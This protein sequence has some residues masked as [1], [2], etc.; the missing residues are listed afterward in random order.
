MSFSPPFPFHAKHVFPREKRTLPAPGVRRKRCEPG[1]EVPD[2][3]AIDRMVS[4]SSP[5]KNTKK[6]GSLQSLYSLVKDHMSLA[7]MTSPFLIGNTSTQSGSIFQPAMLVYRSV[8]GVTWEPPFLCPKING[9]M[10]ENTC[11]TGDISA[12]WVIG[13]ISATTFHGCFFPFFVRQKSLSTQSPK[14]KKMCNFFHWKMFFK[15]YKKV[16][17]NYFCKF[18]LQDMKTALQRLSFCKCW[19][20][21]NSGDERGLPLLTF[22]TW[23]IG[24]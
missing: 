9:Q 2:V 6:V 20:Q 3:C 10:A 23:L 4:L 22:I 8:N 18:F 24:D 7:G 15:G 16:W 21:I 5:T 11:V 19:G 14:E 17:R 13:D 12:K 1:R